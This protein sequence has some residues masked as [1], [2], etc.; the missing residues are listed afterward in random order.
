MNPRLLAAVLS[1]ASTGSFVGVGF[2]QQRLTSYFSIFTILGLRTFVGGIC[3]LAYVLILEGTFST[4][5]L[6]SLLFFWWTLLF[7]CTILLY[8]FAFAGRPLPDVYLLAALMP[9]FV[10]FI[11]ITFF[12]RYF[13]LEAALPLGTMLLSAIAPSLYKILVL[14]STGIVSL[15]SFF[16]FGA[17]VVHAIWVVVGRVVQEDTQ[18]ASPAG[19]ALYMFLIGGLLLIIAS[20][21][22]AVHIVEASVRGLRFQT[23]YLEYA[24]L[25]D[26]LNLFFTGFLAAASVLLLIYAL[27]FDTPMNIAPYQYTV[28]AWA[29]AVTILAAPHDSENSATVL[30]I[31]AVSSCVIVACAFWLHKVQSR[32]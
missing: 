9:I 19:R 11:E 1:V 17:A 18:S 20:N 6:K 5:T 25:P 27:S 32:L 4:V 14:R 10:I 12:R 3:L 31:M 23:R 7:V 21:I 16:A 30:W 2:F 22:D 29:T 8:G 24:E 15:G 26:N 28:P 13:R